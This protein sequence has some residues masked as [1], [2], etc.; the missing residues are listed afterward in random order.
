MV[1][2]ADDHPPIQDK[3]TPKYDA[4]LGDESVTRKPTKVELKKVLETKQMNSGGNIEQLRVCATLAN[5]PIIETKGNIV[6]GHVNKAKGAAQ[7]LC[8]R[9][10]ADTSS[11]LSDG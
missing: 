8:E 1:F 6:D 9:G 2:T 3:N 5:I 10:F 7:I 11:R 4:P